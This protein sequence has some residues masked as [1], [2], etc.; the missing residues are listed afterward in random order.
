MIE[1]KNDL[2][3]GYDGALYK[4]PAFMGGETLR[5]GSLAD[6]VGDYAQCHSS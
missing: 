6:G 4:C 5:I 2:V 3:V 1:F